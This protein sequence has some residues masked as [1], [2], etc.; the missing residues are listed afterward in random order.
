MFR[1]GGVNLLPLYCYGE[2]YQRAAKQSEQIAERTPNL[3]T[4]IVNEI[5][6]KLGLLLLS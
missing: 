6:K 2:R 4:E 1:R 5:A 3:N